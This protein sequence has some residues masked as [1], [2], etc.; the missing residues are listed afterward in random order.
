MLNHTV[1]MDAVFSIAKEKRKRFLTHAKT[2]AE[3][4]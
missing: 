4:E 2:D 3:S 1:S